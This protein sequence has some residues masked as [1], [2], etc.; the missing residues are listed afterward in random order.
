ME[1][2]EKEQNKHLWS[3]DDTPASDL[4]CANAQ[5]AAEGGTLPNSNS[6]AA[7][8][9]TKQAVVGTKAVASKWSYKPDE[10]RAD[11]PFS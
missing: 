9:A 5:A 7:K 3:I 4:L 2:E 10:E 6:R 8:S 1:L 11:N